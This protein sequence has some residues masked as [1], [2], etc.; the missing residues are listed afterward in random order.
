[1]R[2]SSALRATVVL[3]VIVVVLGG[4]YLIGRS[5][6]PHA[7]PSAEAP[8][9]TE[10]PVPSGVQM[11]TGSAQVALTF[12]DGPDPT[13]T[14]LVLKTLRQFHVKA[15]FCLLGKNAE[16]YPELVRAIVA[17]G[18]TL[19]NHTWNEDLDLG[20]RPR[21]D[22]ESNLLRTSQA[23]HVAAPHAPITYFRQPGGNWTRQLVDVAEDLGMTSLH[24]AVDPRDWE[25]PAAAAI[26]ST[27][28]KGTAAGSIVLL[29]DGGGDRQNT[30]TALATLLPDLLSR[31]QLGALP[32]NAPVTGPTS[33]PSPALKQ[34]G[35]P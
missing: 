28:S 12:N 2:R 18:H 15:T 23:I 10:S 27:I 31:F 16:A 19:C 5:L 29:H 22:I 20:S 30:V 26:I 13:W 3:T 1:M 14:P 9:A 8:S 34:G 24:W 11:T 25:E 6:L 4:V 32:V 35:Q 21:Q 17:D 7:S 33:A